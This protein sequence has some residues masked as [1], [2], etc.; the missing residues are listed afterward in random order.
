MG[1]MHENENVLSL[2]ELREMLEAQFPQWAHLP[3]RS[4]ESAGTVNTIYR[5]G[6][7]FSI[8]VPKIESGVAQIE[9]ER[10]FLP[11]LAK[12]LPLEIPKQVAIGTSSPSYPWTWAIYEWIEGINATLE[13]IH[14]PNENAQILARFIHALQRIPSQAGPKPG[15]HN[16]NRGEPLQNRN[17]AT[18]KAIEQLK[19]QI[20]TTIALEVWNAGLQ[21]SLNPLDI[22]WIHGDL[23]A[24]NILARD[25]KITAI[26]DFGALGVGDKACDLMPAWNLFET[27][28]RFLFKNALAVEEDLWIRG[29]AWALSVAVI[30]LPYYW[31]TNPTLA[32][33]SKYTIQSIEQEFLNLE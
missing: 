5:L 33:I 19:G 8:R 23:Q 16:Y 31:K 24:G 1:K 18:L 28:A 13:N 2:T 29:R 26:I 6:E 12:S 22:T 27:E 15:T 3:I 10:D 14:S 4:F 7:Q 9:K 32:A 20:N 30:A 21:A 11:F 25:G 17:E